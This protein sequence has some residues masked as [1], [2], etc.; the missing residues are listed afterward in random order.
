MVAN[1]MLDYDRHSS[2]RR[3]EYRQRDCHLELLP[4]DGLLQI[5]KE[6]D[7]RNF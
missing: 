3:N 6:K 2:R 7:L 5:I 1:H 4:R